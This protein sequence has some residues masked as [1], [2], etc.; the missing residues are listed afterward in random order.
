[1]KVGDLVVQR[2]WENDGA[3]IVIRVW[4]PGSVRGRITVQWCKGV[5]D[6][7]RTQLEGIS[8]NR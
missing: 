4:N 8:A 3:G 1:M 2:G 6:M 5:V 7:Y